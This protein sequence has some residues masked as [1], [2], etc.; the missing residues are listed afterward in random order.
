MTVRSREG[1]WNWD[2]PVESG[3]EARN[4]GLVGQSS[5]SDN[6]GR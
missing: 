6:L 5:V 1:V 2:E 4:A 3:E